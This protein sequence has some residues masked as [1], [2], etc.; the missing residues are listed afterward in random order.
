MSL[1]KNEIDTILAIAALIAAIL[2]TISR[3]RW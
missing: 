2:T 3:H 1:S